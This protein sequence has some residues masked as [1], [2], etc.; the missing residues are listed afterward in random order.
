M[1]QPPVQGWQQQQGY[2]QPP[3]NYDQPP[4]PYPQQQGQWAQQP[5][6]PYPSQQGQLQQ[7]IT[8]NQQWVQQ[9]YGQPP[10]Q[11]P[12][13]KSKLKW[14][15]ISVGVLLVLCI[16]ACALLNSAFNYAA[17]QATTGNIATDTTSSSS[18]TSSSNSSTNSNTSSNSTTT[19]IGKVGDTITVDNVSCTFV[20]V[21]TIAGDDIT[22]PKPGNEFI[23]VHIKIHNSSSQQ[24]DYN[25]FDFHAKSGPGN[26]TDEEL[27]SPSTYTANNQLNN[28]QLDPG[29]TVEGD[30]IFQVL[31][32]D[33]KA[34][35]TWQPSIFGNSTQNAWNLGL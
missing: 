27:V 10:P 16:G 17:K 18:N 29:G 8:P 5:Y 7:P 9:P 6:T 19:Q 3:T 34:E 13:K 4:S 26:V 32:G 15:L 1:Q 11:Q 14:V 33:H 12:K 28:G 21:K 35:L 24:T 20:S 22:L 23:V 30:I 2:N 25:A 31:V